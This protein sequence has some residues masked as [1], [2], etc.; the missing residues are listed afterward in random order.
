M[1]KKQINKKLSLKKMTIAGLNG[2]S[3]GGVNG[4]QDV[5]KPSYLYCNTPTPSYYEECMSQNP[6]GCL[7]CTMLC[8][9][10]CATNARAKDC[11]VTVQVGC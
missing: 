4:G 6:T 7:D 11:Q 10:I 8:T 5:Q 2:R 3:M 1:K 9:Y